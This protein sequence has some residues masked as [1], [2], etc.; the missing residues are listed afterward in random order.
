MRKPEW[1]RVKAG[2]SAGRFG[3][4]KSMLRDKTRVIPTLTF[5]DAPILDLDAT[6]PYADVLQAA[7]AALEQVPDDP[8]YAAIGRVTDSD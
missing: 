5:N 6:A 8:G 4:I 3:E 7:I 2:N 1:I